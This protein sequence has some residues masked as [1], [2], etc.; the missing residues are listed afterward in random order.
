MVIAQQV[1][2]WGRLF[3]DEGQ[4]KRRRCVYVRYRDPRYETVAE[5][6]KAISNFKYDVIICGIDI[7]G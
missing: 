3:N 5:L 7:D 6:T 4:K 2:G 1:P